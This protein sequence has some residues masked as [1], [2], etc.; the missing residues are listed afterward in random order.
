MK[1][2][3]PLFSILLCLTINLL[4]HEEE[5]GLYKGRILIPPRSLS[6]LDTQGTK[7]RKK[8]QTQNGRQCRIKIVKKEKKKAPKEEEDLD[9]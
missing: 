9:F 3:C 7:G 2:P 1:I 8:E 5:K 4:A 6:L